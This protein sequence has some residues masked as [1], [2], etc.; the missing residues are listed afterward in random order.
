MQDFLQAL[1]CDEPYWHWSKHF[2]APL[3]RMGVNHLDDIHLITPE[4][5]YLFFRLP[6]I[7]IMDL[8]SRIVQAIQ[9]I[10]QARPLLIARQHHQ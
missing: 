2:H 8:F 3:M 4:S 7:L 6:P 1:D 10:H 9:A 5:L